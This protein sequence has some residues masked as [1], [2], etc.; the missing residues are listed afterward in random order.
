MASRREVGAAQ[1]IA[2][3]A[4]A[5]NLDARGYLGIDLAGQIHFDRRVDGDEIVELAQYF[6]AMRMHK[7]EHANGRILVSKLVQPLAS[8]QRAANSQPGIDGL[9]SVGDHSSFHEIGNTVA[10]QSRVDAEVAAVAD[11]GQD[12]IG[13]CSDAN[14]DGR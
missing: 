8:T 13:N 5:A 2:L 11:V 1:E 14:L 9:A 7:S 4:D 12:R 3:A 10:D 6:R